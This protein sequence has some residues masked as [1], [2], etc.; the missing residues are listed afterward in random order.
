MQKA[1]RSSWVGSSERDAP[2]WRVDGARCVDGVG[3]GEARDVARAV[4]GWLRLRR[5]INGE[6]QTPRSGLNKTRATARVSP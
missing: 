4:Q 3:V 6:R 2:R 1:S 5:E